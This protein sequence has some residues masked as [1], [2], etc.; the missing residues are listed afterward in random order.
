M[1]ENSEQKLVK[2]INAINIIYIDSNKKSNL[3][4]KLENY[5][6]ANILINEAN[7]VIDQI[8]KDVQ[9]I[10]IS[11]IDRAS[12]VN[13]DIFKDIINN[14][15]PNIREVVYAIGQL[16]SIFTGIPSTQ[17]IINHVDREVIYE[18]VDIPEKK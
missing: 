5:R 4:S 10:D 7:N 17:E 13:I 3:K 8:Q 18:E 16:K 11:K 14:G 6:K 12:N 15:N 9:D 1:T 2:L